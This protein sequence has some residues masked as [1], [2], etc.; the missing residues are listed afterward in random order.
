MSRNVAYVGFVVSSCLFSPNFPKMD[1]PPSWIELTPPPTSC[2]LAPPL[3]SPRDQKE[4]GPGRPRTSGGERRV[5]PGTRTSRK[6][7]PR[8]QKEHGPGQLRS[9]GGE[10][11]V[12]PGTRTRR[13]YW[14][15]NWR[16]NDT[17]RQAGSGWFLCNPQDGSRFL[18]QRV[19]ALSG[20]N[21]RK[22]SPHW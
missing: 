5:I 6:E 10:R 1:H 16:A 17:T 4:H 3:C 12:T 21:L 14:R 19:S 7:D 18:Q 2:S 11:R 13:K 22:F 9:S 8:D 15:A 20:P